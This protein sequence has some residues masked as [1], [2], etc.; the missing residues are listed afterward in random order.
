[1]RPVERLALQSTHDSPV[2]RRH[3]TWHA[4]PCSA[5]AVTHAATTHR[6]HSAHCTA[7]PAPLTFASFT[8]SPPAAI[9]SEL[10]LGHGSTREMDVFLTVSQHSLARTDI[11]NCLELQLATTVLPRVSVMLLSVRVRDSPWPGSNVVWFT[12]WITA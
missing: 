4:A 1:M 2:R 10:F 3:A 9:S 7:R 8:A 12:A 6:P 5:R 11:T